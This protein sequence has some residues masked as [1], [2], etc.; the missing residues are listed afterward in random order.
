MI[1]KLKT[2]DPAAPLPN[3][4]NGT[5]T[6]E[7]SGQLR[8][9]QFFSDPT[10][11][12]L[13]AQ[14]LNSNQELK[15]L[16]QDIQIANTVFLARRGAIWPFVSVRAGAGL[17]RHSRYTWEGAAVDQL[18][19]EPGKGFP[20]PYPDFLV[21]AN[22]TWQVDIW[23]KLRNARD[24]AALRYLGTI[25][26]R[27]YVV[28]RLI[29]DIAQNY[30]SLL[31]L[32][33]R[34]QVLDQTIS[35]QE[36]SLEVAKENLAAGRG[37]QL[38]VQRFTAEVRKNQAEKLIVRQ[39]IIE[40]E[41]RINFLAGRFPQG[42][43]RPFTYFIDLE[44]HSLSSG[45]PAQLLLNRPDIRQAERELEAAGLEIRI[46]RAEFF[47]QLD[48]T[49]GVGYRAFNPKY[50]FDPGSLIAN[51]AGDLVAPLVNRTAIQAA[52]QAAN[53]RQLQALYNYQRTIL[54]AFTEVINRLAMVENYTRSIEIRKQQLSALEQSVAVATQLFQQARVEYVEVLLAQRD[55]L[56]ARTV[57]IESKRRQLTA[58][59][60]AYQALGG[61]GSTWQM[62]PGCAP[63]TQV[64]Q[65]WPTPGLLP[66]PRPL[67]DE[68]P[69][70]RPVPDKKDKIDNPK[71]ENPKID[72]PKDAKKPEVQPIS[73]SFSASPPA[74]P[75][76]PPPAPVQQPYQP[77]IPNRV[78][79]K[80]APRSSPVPGGQ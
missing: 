79:W 17:E 40:T 37:T 19:F 39:E 11:L 69:P 54:E 16:A 66:A 20:R 53:A 47:P 56:E 23:R 65:P 38:P 8:I 51:A 77:A 60:E 72:N 2:P 63:G 10:L 12:C 7:N 42:V 43:E 50:L 59:V 18:Q 15:M 62:L 28:T 31:A 49:G 78:E 76:E 32:D 73:F 70:P 44:L 46:A 36:K 6:Q 58:I 61:G 30:Y 74:A 22:V 21:A 33:A 48:I 80:P 5:I 27:N 1:P 52:F 24:A 75:P 67:P 26:G 34:L 68:L 3:T 35:I 14:G 55:M 71:I 13:I 45:V 9:D 64:P 25:D 29:S 4:F 57:L 41:N